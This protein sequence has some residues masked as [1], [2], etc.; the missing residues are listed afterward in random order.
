MWI[1]FEEVLIAN[2]FWVTE[3][4]NPY[5]VLQRRKGHG[6]RGFSSILVG[7]I[8]SVFDTKPPPYR[9]L[10]Q[11]TNSEVSYSVSCAIKKDEIY[12][13]WDWIETNLMPTL[14]SF[15]SEDDV[16]DFVRCKVESLIAQAVSDITAAQPIES[17]DSRNFRAASHKFA[18]LF[19]MPEEE[20][21]VNYYSCSYWNGR[22][23]R[24]GWLYLSV[25]HL[26]FY[27][28][29][30]GKELKLIIKWVDI[31]NLERD[32]TVL[33]PDSIK[34]VTR[35]KSYIFSLFLKTSETYNLMEQLANLTMRQIISDERQLPFKVDHNLA[36]KKSKNVPKKVSFLKRDLDARAMS[37]SYRITFRLPSNEK[38]DGTLPLTL[39]TPYNKQH[40]WGKMYLSNNYVCFESRVKSLVSLIIPLR[41][42]L[43]TEKLDNNPNTGYDRNNAILISCLK[44]NFIF[45]HIDDRDFLVIKISELLSR[46]TEDRR[47]S[48]DSLSRQLSTVDSQTS[49][50]PEP[51]L[52]TKFPF[53]ETP[54]STAK[55]SVKMNLWELHFIEYGRGISCYRTAKAR[56]LILKGIPDNI[57][58][59]L[60]MLYSGAI[61]EL[62]TH[63]GYYELIV[64]QSLGTHSI[65]T[66]EIERDLHR[67]LPEHPAFQSTLGINALRRVLNA[68]A[69][70]NPN[71][72]YCQAMNI[73]ASVLLLYASEE[74]AFWLLV[75]L[76][77]RL[78]PD[79]YNTKVIGALVDQGVLEELVKEH[80][81]ELYN[82]LIPF[83]I[84]SMIS[85]SWFLT[86]FLSVMPFES[87]I[88]IADC[89]FYDGAKV[90]FSVALNILASNSE[91][92]M[93]AKDD[94]EAMTVL[95]G[96]LENISNRDA[97]IPHI[98][99]SVAYGSASKR[100]SQTSTEIND[101]IYDS[102]SK[103]G[104][105]SANYIEKLRVK[106][107]INV[108]QN[109]E[110]NTMKN[111]I[112]SLQSFPIISKYLTSDQIKDIY[113]I[114]KEEQ[115]RQQYWGQT[116]P[117]N[118]KF[119]LS[120][121]FYEIFKLDMDQFRWYFNHSWP[122]AQA[123]NTD[124]LVIR[125]FKLL[126]E[127]TDNFINFLEFLVLMVVILRADAEI[128]L[129]F[130]YSIHLL[131]I[132]ELI[133]SPSVSEYECDSQETEL[134]A[135]AE[136]FFASTEAETEPK[137]EE[138]NVSFTFTQFL[139]SINIINNNQKN[140]HSFG[141]QMTGAIFGSTFSALNETSTSGDR[142]SS[143][144]VMNQQQFIQLWKTLYD[145]FTGEDNEQQ[146]Y[147]CI[148][149]VGTYL[150]KLGELSS[151]AEST[152]AN[153]IESSDTLAAN[154]SECDSNDS[155]KSDEKKTL[156]GMEDNWFITFEQFCAALHTEQQLVDL[157]E[158]KYDWY[159]VLAK[160][161][162]W[163]IEKQNS[164]S[165]SNPN[166]ITV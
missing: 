103:Y 20:K 158:V 4:A 51:A 124:A 90:V 163:R 152:Q 165:S 42:I 64:Q 153:S 123:E 56:E 157:F 149:S 32:S 34:I 18:K 87:A 33:F 72:G 162:N 105:I 66:D 134:G 67:S 111:V 69:F 8:D 116:L 36:A 106:H 139:S 53:P 25:N 156:E 140:S 54:E 128:K 135:E 23:P 89:F 122:W 73:V 113:V 47:S 164:F 40:V 68:Y 81:P 115:L 83:G 77:E 121:P 43:S 76:C 35:D 78:L 57:R 142:R 138:P 108:V 63:R 79:Y 71:I 143:L 97:K 15:E 117:A 10:H 27:S 41:E 155:T 60:W 29:L 3:R 137:A 132:P 46:L 150:L 37:E 1:K 101:L 161:K 85:L 17:T 44:S 154:S 166:V 145:I 55:E 39:W 59:E 52:S 107:R 88:H 19:S 62:S 104:F 9:I 144:P 126:D 146:I 49:W 119:D 92:L 50:L 98:V 22:L 6:T 14:I 159:S 109:L 151:Q 45:S 94:G 131:N 148:A 21:L 86:I 48:I 74:E 129:R 127:N 75:A 11:T 28:Y 58:G 112:R 2:A 136:E 61:N 82:K 99:H 95:S 141:S 130:I 120:H 133:S 102:Y 110:D 96:Y 147:H 93:A 5:F 114:F 38:L 125:I 100:A 16:T 160:L 84:L 13:D 65:A 26:C 70:R 31:K 12:K 30:F 7:T 80:L 118:E 91:A 24:Q